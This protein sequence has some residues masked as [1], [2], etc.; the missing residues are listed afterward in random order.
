[1]KKKLMLSLGCLLAALAFLFYQGCFTE[2]VYH[3]FAPSNFYQKAIVFRY[4]NQTVFS[5]ISLP[6]N[7]RYVPVMTLEYLFEDLDDYKRYGKNVN[8]FELN[9]IVSQFSYYDI[10]PEY[11][12]LEH[13]IYFER[14]MLTDEEFEIVVDQYL[15][16]SKPIYYD[17]LLPWI[18]Y[19]LVS[20]SKYAQITQIWLVDFT[21]NIQSPE[22]KQIK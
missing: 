6:R 17:S 13:S 1:M 8:E 15:N 18:G 7:D 22:I 14:R 21:G 4:Q 16:Y 5:E 12:S 2:V 3:L 19:K 9:E 10:Y 11:L 20:P